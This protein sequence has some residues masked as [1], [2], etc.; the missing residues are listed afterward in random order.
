MHISRAN[1]LILARA[2]FIEGTAIL[3]SRE[4]GAGRRL[5]P[6]LGITRSLLPNGSSSP[7]CPSFPLRV[8][9]MEKAGERKRVVYS[10]S[11]VKVFCPRHASDAVGQLD[12]WSMVL[13]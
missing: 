8:K 12:D 1:F 5:C 11:Y 6:F 3:S 9:D 4:A 13:R 10:V 7:P 2:S